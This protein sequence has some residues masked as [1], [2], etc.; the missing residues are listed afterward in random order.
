MV[1]RSLL[2]ERLEKWRGKPI[3]KVL[4]GVRRCGKSVLLKQFQEALLASGVAP[5][6]I[7][8]VD[9]EDLSNEFLL[10]YRAL[11]DHVVK[12]L[13]SGETT[14][15]F[16]DEVQRVEG[17]Q[18]TVDSLLLRPGVDIYM[19]GSNASLLSGELATL[20]SGRYVEIEVLPFSFAEY[21]SRPGLD[22]EEAWRRY[23]STGGFPFL[24]GIEDRASR[25]DYLAGIFNTVLVKDIL[26]RKTLQDAPLLERIAAF[27]A[28]NAGSP[29]SSSKI[30]AFLTSGGRKTVPQ[31]VDHYLRA[32][33]DAFLFYR[34]PRWDLRGKEQLKSLS[35]HYMVDPGLRAVLLSHPDR[36]VGHVL[37]NFVFLELRRRG[38]KTFTGKI[39]N[40]EI[41][42]VAERD[43]RRL[44]IQV[45]ATVLDDAVYEREAAPLRA[46]RDGSGRLLLSLDATP[47]GEDG[48]RHI[49]ARDFLGGAA[50]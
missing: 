37:E 13:K 23:F 33:D 15:V 47:R 35:K 31:T 3:V 5:D 7:V 10:D 12:R 25:I 2:L 24:A 22:A 30:S 4:T 40:R 36:D 49:H 6:R 27:L 48:I 17:F 46:V 41:D 9:F 1:Q 44:C 39:A 50:I 38:W 21:A 18:K 14:Y 11:H 34:V 42:F 29:V 16:L 19:T 26:A 32:L 8:S 43:G 45:A 20:L 28:G